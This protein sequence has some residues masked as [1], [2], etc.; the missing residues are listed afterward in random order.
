MLRDQ[1]D[2]FVS[3]RFSPSARCA[4]VT[5]ETGFNSENWSFLAELGILSLFIEEAHGGLGGTLEDVLQIAEAFGQGVVT[6]P[7]LQQIIFAAGLMQRAGTQEQKNEWLPKVMSHGAHLAVAYAEPDAR[8]SIDQV[9]S[10]FDGKKLTGFK[11][12]VSAGTTCDAFIVTAR[13]PNGSIGLFLVNSNSDGVEKRPY[14]LIDG[15]PALEISFS[16]VIAEPMAGGIDCLLDQIDVTR[17]AISAELLGLMSLVF[18]STLAYVKERKQFGR[19]IGSFQAIQHRLAMQYLRIEQARSQVFRAALSSD[20][21]RHAASLAA[22]S[23]VSETAKSLGEE[24]IQLHGGMGV[25]DE[26][27]IGHAHKRI[28]LLNSLFGDPD[29]EISRYMSATRNNGTVHEQDQNPVQ[30]AA[31]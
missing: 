6:E 16:E 19:A 23:F 10:F 30:V 9:S 12:F 4:D 2:R 3:E 8:Y 7:W 1:I 28:L 24:S 25:T 5:P 31:E 29:T 22:K 27:I 20:E 18:D 26:L 17:I 15:S 11:T 21:D 14:R 13:A